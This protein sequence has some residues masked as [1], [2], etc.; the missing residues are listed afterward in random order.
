MSQVAVA[1]DRRYPRRLVVDLDDESYR[2]LKTK[3]VDDDI[4]IA[5]RIRAL[6]ELHKA[7]RA[8]REN[9]DSLAKELAKADYDQRYRRK[10]S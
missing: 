4:S 6:V 5:H 10:G 1:S 8:V 7:D 2:Y 3:S 9:A